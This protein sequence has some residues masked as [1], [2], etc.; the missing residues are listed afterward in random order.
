VQLNEYVIPLRLSD[1]AVIIGAWRNA[2]LK[3]K[4]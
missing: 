1:S 2:D 4:P 3:L